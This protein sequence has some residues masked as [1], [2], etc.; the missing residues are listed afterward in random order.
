MEDDMKA[1]IGKVRQEV[2]VLM[3][4]TFSPHD[5]IDTPLTRVLSQAVDLLRD[6][7]KMT[8]H[9]LL[10]R[11]DCIIIRSGI[12]AS[13]TPTFMTV[14]GAQPVLDERITPRKTLPDCPDCLAILNLQAEANEK[15]K[16][17]NGNA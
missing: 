9:P 14:C 5:L 16:R 4:E 15:R 11:M 13:L 12:H 10:D 17:G 2:I 3:T 8:E 1:R 7:A 6:A